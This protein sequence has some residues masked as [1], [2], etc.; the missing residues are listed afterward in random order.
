MR[1]RKGHRFDPGP[2]RCSC[3]S[4]CIPAAKHQLGCA[5]KTAVSSL[6]TFEP[7]KNVILQPAFRPITDVIWG[8]FFFPFSQLL[9]PVISLRQLSRVSPRRLVR[10]FFSPSICCFSI[11]GAGGKGEKKGKKNRSS[12]ACVLSAPHCTP[13]MR[14]VPGIWLI[15]IGAAVSA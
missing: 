2:L 3:C 8:I 4:V 5:A 15:M 11:Q 1:K 7:E 10:H 12:L 6:P 14:L 13:A 9:T